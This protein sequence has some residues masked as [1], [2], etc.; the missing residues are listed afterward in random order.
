MSYQ[1]IVLM[2]EVETTI[3]HMEEAGQADQSIYR[4][5][6]EE[7]SCEKIEQWGHGLLGCEFILSKRTG[8]E[9]V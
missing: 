3:N 7:Q 9:V 1:W 2:D 6:Q 4:G 8:Y 5:K